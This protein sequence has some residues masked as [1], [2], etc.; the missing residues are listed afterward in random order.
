[1]RKIVRIFVVALLL[2]SVSACGVQKS[3]IGYDA[4]EKFDDIKIVDI[5]LTEEDYG[6]GVDKDQ[7]ELLEAINCFIKEYEENGKFKE[8]CDHYSGG[9]PVGIVSKE[10]NASRDQLVVAT[11]GDFKPFDYVDGELNYGIDKEYVAAL[12]DYLGKELVIENLNFDIM[13]MTVARHK[14]DICIA[15]ITINDARKKYV[16]FS[17][18]YYHAGQILVT[19]E[20]NTLFDGAKSVADVEEIL[21]DPGNN[22]RVAVENMT[23]GHYYCEG[24]SE[25][26]YRGFPVTITP[27]ASL[28]GCLEELER[29]NVDIVIGDAAVLKYLTAN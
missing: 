13:F 21:N 17:D 26:G 7:P 1:M 15:G 5:D 28:E 24:D 22:L 11:T 4:G 14:A 8:I 3:A 27:C 18:P 19:K 10:R 23:I 20:N 9:E 25:F 29:G 2:F 16:D 6:I 12:A